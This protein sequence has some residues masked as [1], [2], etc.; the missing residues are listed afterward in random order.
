[1]SKAPAMQFYVKD[2]QADTDGLC[3]A[4]KGAYIQICCKLHLAKRRGTMTRTLAA[5]ARTMGTDEAQAEQLLRE[6]NDDDCAHVTFRNSKVTVMSRRMDRERKD[7]ESNRLRVARHR[8]KRGGNE[9]VTSPSASA[10][11]SASATAQK[12]P[13]K[14]PLGEPPCEVAQFKPV[15]SREQ[16]T[17]AD[18]HMNNIFREAFTIDSNIPSI[19]NRDRWRDG[20][21]REGG[22]VVY[23]LSF[24][25][26]DIRAAF[27][28]FVDR[29]NKR[30][31]LTWTWIQNARNRR[32]TG[33]H[34]QELTAKKRQEATEAAQCHVADDL[35]AKMDAEADR[36]ARDAWWGSVPI[37]QRRAWIKTHMNEV[38][39]KRIEWAEKN[40]VTA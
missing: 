19:P 14:S 20:I 21:F 1:M 17:K 23:F 9:K 18:E 12:E 38:L 37:P 5:W 10:S 35:A 27:D 40:K 16:I 11:S 32:V 6:I 33:G 31:I 22:T 30:Q 13:P 3:V 2:W 25:E 8:A 15:A 26:A 4:A 24:T 34:E 39:A 28:A 7:K 29:K 36:K